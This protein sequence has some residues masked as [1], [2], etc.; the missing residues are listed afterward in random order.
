M[1]KE[2]LD[3]IVKWRY[4]SEVVKHIVGVQLYSEKVT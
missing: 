2:S 4:L 1:R 3:F